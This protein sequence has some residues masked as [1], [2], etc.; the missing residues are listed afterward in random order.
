MKSMVRKTL[1]QMEGLQTKQAVYTGAITSASVGTR[2][3]GQWYIGST[4]DMQTYLGVVNNDDK[5]Y[6]LRQLDHDVWFSNATNAT[7]RVRIYK[8][9]PRRC[10]DSTA[11]PFNVMPLNA[12]ALN[13][14]GID[15]TTGSEFRRLYKITKRITR[16]VPQQG[17]FLVKDRFYS[18]AG[19]VITGEVEGSSLYVFTPMSRIFLVFAETQAIDDTATGVN[20]STGVAKLNY[21]DTEKYTYY[22]DTAANDPNTSATTGLATTGTFQLFTDVQKVTEGTDT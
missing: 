8:I 17:T 15:P 20:T 9:R 3:Y 18:A 19:K 16:I 4:S 6:Y 7:L 10:I 1:L 5:K 13:I 21:I 14:P 2:A 22:V 11:G 12:P